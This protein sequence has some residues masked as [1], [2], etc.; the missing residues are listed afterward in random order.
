MGNLVLLATLVAL[1]I[2]AY[3]RK[4]DMVSC[5]FIATTMFSVSATVVLV[6]EN[7]WNQHISTNTVVIILTAL[8]AVLI[9]EILGERIH[10]SVLPIKPNGKYANCREIRNNGGNATTLLLSS[11]MIIILIFYIRYLSRVVVSAGFAGGI[12]SIMSNIK[13]ASMVDD[14]VQMG[15]LL[16]QAYQ[17][18]KCI[19]YYYIY[20]YIYNIVYKNRK[21]LNLY[22]L[23]SLLFLFSTLLSPGRQGL[24][25]VFI[26]AFIVFAITYE[27]K[28][29]KSFRIKPKTISIVA[30]LFVLLII[31]VRWLSVLRNS[32]VNI[33]SYFSVYLGGSI[34]SFDKYVNGFAKT[35]D[36]PENFRAIASYLTAFGF[37]IPPVT[38]NFEPIYWYSSTGELLMT[39]IFTA[40]RR[41]IHDFGFAGLYIICG[42]IGAIYSSAYKRIR[43]GMVSH[44]GIAF[45]ASCLYPIVNFVFEESFLNEV[46]S[47]NTVL[48]LIYIYILFRYFTTYSDS[49]EEA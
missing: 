17:L 25:K 6:N 27:K 23:P 32:D 49:I 30:L 12:F 11:I 35:S 45:F 2:L 13:V 24:I 38:Y 34:V 20:L 26:Y 1:A 9:G 28:E 43:K 29:G 4:K 10:V 3:I 44:A 22:L 40:F 7:N 41:Y 47:I 19:G 14:P 5:T 46:L 31:L 16:S 42:S 15:S 48:N 39:N 33:A 36:N 37:N 18:M 8:I 21:A